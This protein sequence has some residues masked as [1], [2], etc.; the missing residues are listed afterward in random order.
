MKSKQFLYPIIATVLLLFSWANVG[1][2]KYAEHSVLASGS[3]TKISVQET[4]VC[5]ITYDQLREMGFSNPKE[6]H[7]YGYGGAMLSENF[8][9][10]KTDDLNETPIY[11]S[12]SA[13]YFYAQ[14]PIKWNYRGMNKK[15]PFDI[16]S[17]IYSSYGYYF[18]TSNSTERNLIGQAPAVEES[19]DEIEITNYLE[20]IVHKKE[21]TN[22]VS[23]G[24]GW[25]GDETPMGQ[26]V[27]LEFNVPD[28]DI[29]ELGSL[30]LSLL[31]H[32]DRNSTARIIFGGETYVQEVPFSNKEAAAMPVEKT[33]VWLPSQ[34]END[35]IITYLANNG[36]DKLW[37]DQ[38]VLSAY[39]KL[40]INNGIMYFRNPNTEELGT[41]KYV[42]TN[43]TPQTIVW[44]I[45]NPQQVEQMPTENNGNEVTFR[46]GQAPMEEFVAFDPSSTQ[47]VKAELAGNVAN[48][49]L[50][51]MQDIDFI[52]ISN[53]AFL[54]EAQRLAELHQEH[55]NISTLVVTPEE[56]FNEFSSGT[57]D[58]SAIRWFLK[59]FYDRGE[60]QKQVLLFGD[61][62]YDNRG[63]L[64]ET[65]GLNYVITY[66]GGNKYQEANSYVSDS[67]FCFLN[68]N[69]N[70][71]L[72]LGEMK[73]DYGIGR[74]PV[75][76]LTQATNMVNKIEK[77][78]T[79]NKYGDW[80][81]K[82]LLVA[83]DNEEG[84]NSINKFFSYSDN[85]GEIIHTKDPSMEIQKVHFDSYTR[86]VGSNGNRYPEVE[87]IIN[88]SIQ[89]GILIMN[90][91][92]HSGEL[93]W[94][95]ERVFTQNQAGTIF[96]EK[97]G[98]WFTASCRFAVFDERVS[99]A[100]EDLILN[101]N[102][103]ALTLFC[104]A[105]TVYDYHNDNLN[106]AYVS[107]LFSRDEETKLPLPIGE[108]CKLAK[109]T[110]DNDSNKMSYTL[111][112]DPMLR[113]CYPKGNVL[114][115]SITLIEGGV[116]DTIHALSEVK[117][118]GHV[119][120]DQNNFMS[121]F[122]GKVDIILYDKEVTLST[123]GNTFETEEEK[124]NKK[125][126]YKDRTTILFSGKAEVKN[127]QFSFVF[128]VPK[129]INYNY[130]TGRIHYYAMDES[131]DYDA[132]GYS[133]KFIIGGSIQNDSQDDCGPDI[134]MY[135]NH[136]AFLSGDK[137]NETPVLFAEISDKNGI[138]ASG[139]GIGHE[140]TLTLSGNQ[141]PIIL[142]K[143]FTYDLDSYSDGTINYQFSKLE[144]GHYTATLKAWDLLNNSSQ[145]SI[146]FVVDYDNDIRTDK[147]TITPSFAKENAQINVFHDMPNTVQNYTFIIYNSLGKII[148]ETTPTQE[149]IEKSYTWEWDLKDNKGTRVPAGTYLVRVEHENEE[150]EHHGLTQK[151]IVLPE[152]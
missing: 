48:Q 4:G 142:N 108:I 46:R 116:T 127:G 77:Y 124:E 113:I 43:A 47:F 100:G 40:K 84:K 66:Q 91:I 6:V 8:S 92:G 151:M 97:Q 70:S 152:K 86:V 94:S 55:D 96:N 140:I 139:S 134:R 101:P 63:I 17:N 38:I 115:D 129:D 36:T 130:G 132:D 107:N 11:D 34:E 60:R 111:F 2:T 71:K 29:D 110:L 31:A 147:V 15:H 20:H 143:D 83:D 19:E 21:E 12:G 27:T 54:S 73:M 93:A 69:N 13:I 75:S 135:M 57:P 90:Y 146:E 26:K 25:V 44:N 1:A 72:S 81:N 106:R 14:G 141:T 78:L 122:N 117:V 103:G 35:V 109:N 80:R 68:D 10:E 22:L 120:D 28:I 45:S 18:L 59:M 7:I 105:R 79:A 62:I 37:V 82:V 131:L 114:T 32:S 65:R 133:E 136:N 5:K 24:K 125:H 88:K 52:I 61:G 137:V 87:E 145:K 128:K 104:A 126:R 148:R 144:P 16:S 98:F 123:K 39:R 30:Y 50:H 9:T 56:I 118:Y 99:S 67:Y 138:N 23:S 53:E 150:G 33:I 64:K 149:R 89:D 95:A 85:I 58:A 51:A 42:I 76:S 112:G 49:D 121:H 119:E 102:G 3:W 74:L 41:Y